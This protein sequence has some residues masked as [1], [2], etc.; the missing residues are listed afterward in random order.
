MLPLADPVFE[1]LPAL[2][3][4]DGHLFNAE[5]LEG[6]RVEHLLDCA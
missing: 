3:T 5:D 6:G 1:Q 2:S 4:R